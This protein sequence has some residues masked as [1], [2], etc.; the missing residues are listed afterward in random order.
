RSGLP[1]KRHL[2][3]VDQLL[4][5]GRRVWLFWPDEQAIECVDR[6]RLDSFR[7]HLKGVSWMKRV[8]VPVDSAMIRWNRVP[9]AL[10]WIYRGEFPVRRSDILVKLTLLTLRAQPVPLAEL[11]GPGVYLRTDYWNTGGG[12][13]RVDG[14]VAALERTSERVVYLTPRADAVAERHGVHQV[15]MDPPRVTSGEDAIVLSPVHYGP[16]VK[17]ACQTVSP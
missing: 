7:R 1:F 14:V 6:E 10:R 17:A 16:I 3:L 5:A 8:A 4:H 15:V 2:E 9:T 11:S 13:E 12:D